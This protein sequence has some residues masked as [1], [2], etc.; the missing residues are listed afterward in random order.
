[1]KMT[2]GEKIAFLRKEKNITQTELAEYLFLA[3]QTVSRWEVGSGAPEI[4]LLPKIAAFF[5]VS[6]DELFGVTS[7]ERAEDLVCKYSVLRDE[8]SFQEA[9]E[10]VNSQLQT[11]DA[12]LKN[13]AENAD[14]LETERDQLEAEKMHL[15]LQQGRES[16]QRA[17]D[18]ADAF[19]KKTEGNPEHPWY[20]RMRLQR[21]QLSI[22]IGKVREALTACRQNFTETPDSTTLCLYFYM[23]NDLHH[24]E[25]LLALQESDPQVQ[26]LTLPPSKENLGIWGVLIHAAAET[27]DPA[28]IERNL[29]PVLEAC[30]TDKEEE[31]ALLL[32]LLH[33]YTGEKLAALKRR[34]LDLLPEVPM[35]RYFAENARQRIEQA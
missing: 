1:M 17:Y 19:V 32:C 27:G 14:G 11:I 28:F 31:Y 4:T 26:K 24:Y 15:L 33:V 8:R 7:L 22:P 13:G 5:S 9:M 18:I 6:I 16:F 2:I 21:N 35:N 34:L 30:G 25:E 12:F 23:L 3:P 20:L 10:C 29:P